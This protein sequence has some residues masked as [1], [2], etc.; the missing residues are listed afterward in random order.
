MTRKV[1]EAAFLAAWASLGEP[2]KVAQHLGLTESQVYKRRR[3]IEKARGVTLNAAT[4]GDAIVRARCEQ[5]HE[6]ELLDGYVVVFSDAHYWPGLVPIAH[7]ALLKVLPDVKP[8]L[9][10]GNGDILDCPNIGR[11]PRIGWQQTPKLADELVACQQRLAEIQKVWPR[12]K[13]RL[14]PGNHDMRFDSMMSNFMPA[15]EGIPGMTLWDHFPAWDVSLSIM[16]NRNTMIKHRYH[17]GA[18]AVFNNAVKSGVH[19]VTGH[20]HRL[21]YDVWGDYNG[22]RF[23]V[24]TGTLADVDGPQ[25]QYGED[26]PKPHSSGF[27][28]LRY[29]AG[30]LLDPEFCRV[31]EDG[32]AY[33]RGERVV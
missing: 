3:R 27:A 15:L 11:H 2:T 24:D 17:S 18:H 21:K 33:F 30:M 10:I 26:N 5:R 16:L 1:T 20:L 12:A 28:V 22:L 23:G 14:T 31:R 19:M 6:M 32:H 4:K 9:I 13:R 8:K 25:F 7:R 29:R